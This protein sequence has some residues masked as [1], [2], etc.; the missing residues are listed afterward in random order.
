MATQQELMQALRKADAAGDNQAAQAIARLI[1]TQGPVAK[2]EGIPTAQDLPIAQP[3]QEGMSAL[4]VASGVSNVVLSGL[5]G[6]A[7]EAVSGIWGIAGAPLGRGSASVQEAQQAI[8]DYPVTQQGQNVISAIAEKY[9]QDP[10]FIKTIVDEISNIGPGLGESTFQATGSPLAATAV[11]MIPALLEAGSG[12][13]GSRAAAKQAASVAQNTPAISAPIEAIEGAAD[14]A[15]TETKRAIQQLSPTKRKITEALESGSSEGVGAGFQLTPKGLIQEAPLEQ[16]ALKQGWS[17]GT[18]AALKN[19]SP[20]DKKAMAQMTRL[21]EQAK[22]DEFKGVGI[23]PARVAGDALLE[24]FNTVKTANKKAGQAVDREAR[25]LAGQPVEGAVEIAD[26]FRRVLDEDLAVS[27]TPEGNLNFYDSI[28][29]DNPAAKKAISDVVKVMKRGKAGE[30]ITAD[31]LHFIKKKIDDAVTFG[32]S[33]EGLAGQA[34][35]ALKDLRFSINSTLRENFPEYGAANQAYSETIDVLDTFQD[36][37]GKKVNLS[38]ER[39]NEAVGRNLRK[40]MSNYNSREQLQDVI[41]NIEEVAVKHGGK[42][43]TNVE[44][45]AFYADALDKRFGKTGATTFGGEIQAAIET[46][47]GGKT[48]LT[49]AAIDKLASTAEELR[50]INDEGA[51][52]AMNELLK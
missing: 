45:L 19:A 3:Q 10:L 2:V 11:Q 12:V 29:E 48:G 36:I 4:D 44:L 28:I 52:K 1:K 30:P 23:R 16:A 42:F 51:F 32:K 21:R 35:A 20:A 33:A 26:D 25:A 50:G 41:Q 18:I 34:E 39:A 40:V 49:A 38:G 27:L 13:A 46:A 37:M 17:E 7:K 15:V 47:M 5:A 8:P 6:A 31:R 24:R 43:D 14:K 22:L 9:N